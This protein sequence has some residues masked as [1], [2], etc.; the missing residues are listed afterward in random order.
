M[1]FR[2]TLNSSRLICEIIDVKLT[3]IWELVLTTPYLLRSLMYVY[4]GLII[5]QFLKTTS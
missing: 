2:G 5:Y 4:G 1:K 3:G